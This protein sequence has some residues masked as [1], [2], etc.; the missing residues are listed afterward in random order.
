ML[1]SATFRSFGHSND[2]N[3]RGIDGVCVS[4]K[5]YGGSAELP[6]WL[7][8]GFFGLTGSAPFKDGLDITADWSLWI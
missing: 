3:Q 6:L 5:R 4:I 1:G 8:D 7:M 2:F